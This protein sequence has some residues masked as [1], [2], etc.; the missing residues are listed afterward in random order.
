MTKH[1]ARQILRNVWGNPHVIGQHDVASIKAVAEPNETLLQT[2]SRIAG[3]DVSGVA[4]FNYHAIRALVFEAEMKL[5]TYVRITDHYRYRSLC[6]LKGECGTIV[7]IL[8]EWF[9]IYNCAAY[10]VDIPGH[11]TYGVFADEIEPAS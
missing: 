5:G 10:M 8:P 1:E 6:A 4:P 7:E 9:H 3:I 2:V 11:G